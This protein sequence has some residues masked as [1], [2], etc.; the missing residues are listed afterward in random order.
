MRLSVV[1]QH[2]A[3]AR[4]SDRVPVW[5]EFPVKFIVNQNHVEPESVVGSFHDRRAFSSSACKWMSKRLSSAPKRT[6][7]CRHKEEQ[8]RFRRGREQG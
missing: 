1:F 3:P 8:D 2:S 4:Q 7:N 6:L 5:F